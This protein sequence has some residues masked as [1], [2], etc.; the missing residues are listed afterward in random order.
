[1][2]IEQ[3]DLIVVGGG[4]GGSAAALRAA[5][6]NL[7]QVWIL[8]D[9]STAKASR[10]KYV[11][12]IDNML[13]IH[14]G[15]LLPKILK[16]LNH[17]KHEEARR[18]LETAEFRIGT[19]DII[20]NAIERIRKD[21]AEKTAMVEEKAIKAKKEGDC[22]VVTTS[23]GRS[24]RAR[25]LVLATGCMDRQPRIMKTT[26]RGKVLDEI[27][28]L[29]PYANHE[30]LL[31]C[32]RC[33]GHLTQ[34][35]RTAVIGAGESTAQV[36]LSLHERYATN[37]ALLTNGEELQAKDETKKLLGLYGISV[38]SG[39]IVELLDGGGKPK[40][41]RLRGFVLED[42]RRVEVRFG[43]IVMG[44]FKV[45]N[46][47]ARQLGAAL[48]SGEGLSDDVRHVLVAERTS[49]TDV[50]GL[51]CVGDMSRTTGSSPSMKQI[52]T[53]QEYAVRA[54]DAIDGRRR[55]A[56]RKALLAS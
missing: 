35:T 17:P 18:T 54:I 1:M 37:V 49:E 47:L 31:Y 51:F 11:Y 9:R 20:Q 46:D 6:Y 39:R 2:Q 14:P 52:Y 44:L 4:I 55:S 30:S 45:Y 40:G 15:L 12:N 34:E 26:K 10:G 5:Q 13:G 29:Y 48:E 7:K 25:N 23:K 22:F 43:M 3:C 42:G 21:Y 24:L 32:I 33:E 27:H 36:A 8:G 53:A 28:W 56:A 50:R 16:L 41:R 19:A 38:C